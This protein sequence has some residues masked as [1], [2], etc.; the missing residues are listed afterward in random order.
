MK[1]PTL[2][3]IGAG[4]MARSLI[5][6]LI[7]DG[8]DPKL[9]WATDPS[10]EKLTKLMQDFNIQTTTDNQEGIANAEVLILAVKPQVMQQVLEPLRN[11]IQQK[12]PLVIS[13]AAMITVDHLEQWLGKDISMVRCMPNTPALVQSGATALFANQKASPLE[14]ATAESILRAVGITLWLER[15]ADLNIVTVISGCG[16]AYFFLLMEMMQQVAIQMGLPVE[17]ARLLSL[18]TAMGAARLALESENDPAVLRQQVTSPGGTTEKIIEVLEEG[19]IRDLFLN[20]LTAGKERTET[21]G[22]QV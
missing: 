22:K 1:K 5:A 20:A 6:G 12:K 16:P 9:I 21:L 19:K 7:A 4:N 17:T 8:Y 11:A 3:F 18:Q 10:K 13:I 14:K 2:A 15:E